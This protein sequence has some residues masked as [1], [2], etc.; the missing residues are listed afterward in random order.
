M[1]LEK[2][3]ILEI[4]FSWVRA[5]SNSDEF[6]SIR[7]AVFKSIHPGLLSRMAGDS[8]VNSAC[9]PESCRRISGDVLSISFVTVS[10]LVTRP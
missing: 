4:I 5:K 7:P 1:D 10:G 2:G 8:D 9:F 6:I 3:E